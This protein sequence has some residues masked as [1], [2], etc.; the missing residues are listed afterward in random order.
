MLHPRVPPL[1]RSLPHVES[2]SL[3]RVEESLDETN[4]REALGL[5]VANQQP[6]VLNSMDGVAITPVISEAIP[7]QL[8][9]TAPVSS[10]QVNISISS[11][12]APSATPPKVAQPTP[13]SRFQPPPGRL[14]SP[15]VEQ[16]S[17]PSNSTV[18]VNVQ[19]ASAMASMDEDEE[20][21]EMPGINMDSDSD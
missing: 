19:P 16:T 11:P 8:S 12:S 9:P 10:K 2:L 15:S 7:L 21:E 14:P 4:A 18:P 13:I 6:K 20:D 3:F 5:G 1:V 17:L